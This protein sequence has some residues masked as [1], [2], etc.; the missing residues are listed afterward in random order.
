M[1]STCLAPDVHYGMWDARA[2]LHCNSIS[3]YCQLAES[4]Y[5]Q[6][7]AAADRSPCWSPDKGLAR[8]DPEYMEGN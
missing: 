1:P 2:E 4:A 5:H 6:A 8:G 3:M 7:Q